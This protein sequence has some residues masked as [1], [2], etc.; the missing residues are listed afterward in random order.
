[1]ENLEVEGLPTPIKR[2][3]KHSTAYHIVK[4][5]RVPNATLEAEQYKHDF[6]H[7]RREK[8]PEGY[9]APCRWTTVV[10]RVCGFWRGRV[11]KRSGPGDAASYGEQPRSEE[12]E[13]EKTQ[14]TYTNKPAISELKPSRLLISERGQTAQH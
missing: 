12:P 5:A 14:T 1:M 2:Y 8:K 11:G 13:N 6:K 4:L 3:G 10:K 9:M 7:A